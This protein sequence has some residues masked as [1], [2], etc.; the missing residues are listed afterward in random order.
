[1]ANHDTVMELKVREVPDTRIAA[2][3]H[4]GAYSEISVAF[5]RLSVV[6]AAQNVFSGPETEMIAV[7]H[8]DPRTTPEETLRS[9]AGIIVPRDRPIPASLTERWIPGGV[10]ATVVHVGPYSELE[11]CWLQFV[12]E[13]IPAA[14]Y[15]FAGLPVFERYLNA[16]DTTAPEEL[17]TVLFARVEKPA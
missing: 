3:R 13:W 7:F 17:R 14:G 2:V 4:I 10:Y 1:M 8:D 12:T 5:D 9:D 6:T 15:L 11:V 16:P